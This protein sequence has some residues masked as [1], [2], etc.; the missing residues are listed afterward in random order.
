MSCST[1]YIVETTQ[2]KNLLGMVEKSSSY[3]QTMKRSSIVNLQ[4]SVSKNSYRKSLNTSMRRHLLQEQ[5]QN[6]KTFFDQSLGCPLST[7]DMATISLVGGNGLKCWKL[8]KHGFPM[9]P[10]YVVPTYVYSLHVEKA[11]VVED[12]RRIFQSDLRSEKVRQDARKQLDSIR[13]KIVETPLTREVQENLD[14]FLDSLPAG[15]FFAV[16]SSATAEDLVSQSFAG[17]YGEL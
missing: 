1:F 10:C 12:I 9:P 11:G 17:Q 5:S 15:A 4:E 2:T 13:F 8:T 14:A 7:F 6:D 3:F 16:R